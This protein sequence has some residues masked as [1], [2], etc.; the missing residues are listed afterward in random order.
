MGRIGLRIF[1]GFLAGV[2]WLG[3]IA[4]GDTLDD[5]ESWNDIAS[6]EK[7]LVFGRFVGKFNNRHFRSRKVRLRE[8]TTGDVETLEID[9]GLG[10]IAETIRPGN[11]DVIGFEA[12]YFPPASGLLD[13]D[14]YRP[15]RQRFMLNPKA[16][17]ATTSRILVPGDRP[18]YIGTI[19]ADNP[20]DGMVYRGHQLRVI[21]DF[22]ES[23]RVLSSSYPT[24]VGSLERQG[25]APARQFMLKP[26]V[27]RDP[28]ERVVGLE[29]PIRQVR[30]Y[31]SDGKYR[32]AIMWLDTFMPASDE[33]RTLA[34]LLVGEALLGDMNYPAAIEELGEALLI[35]PNNARALRL[36]ARAHA[37]D[38][39]I[40]D[41]QNLYE[42]LA[43]LQPGDAEAHLHLGYFYALQ[44][45]GERARE[46]FGVAFAKDF[47]YLL[48]DL[49]PFY[50]AVREAV[51]IQ[52][53]EYQPPRVK[54][55]TVPPPRGM[56][57]RRQATG[58]GFSVLVD[59]EGN[60][61]AAQIG[62][63]SEGSSPMMMMSLVK[64]TYEP[65]SLNGIPIPALFTIGQ[66]GV[67]TQ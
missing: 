21:D 58:S 34:K 59:H 63:R 12:T 55:F 3:S 50:I 6:D 17:E 49:A 48:H 52:D 66:P 1:I 56:N 7:S 31:I 37:F 9:D 22:D 11:Y 39:N 4:H 53:G 24:L 65:A 16:G 10:H 51:D 36:L 43:E 40:E 2:L 5:D 23:Y 19:Q 27:V 25:I 57:S 42:G 13:P 45:E 20:S 18:V 30:D 44:D 54:R 15:L 60:V 26:S 64:A 38:G 47:D 67:P 46:E 29:D 35:D 41:A 8:I 28:L 14:R 32:Q 33:E 62:N 61:I